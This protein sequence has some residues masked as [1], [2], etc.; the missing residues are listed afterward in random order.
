M[1]ESDVVK[2][3]SSKQLAPCKDHQIRDPITNR[4]RNKSGYKTK[5]DEQIVKPVK[6]S[7]L[8]SSKQLAPCKD[9]QIRDPVTNR[10]RNKSGYKTK[11]DEQITKP[12]KSSKRKSSKQLAPCKDHQIR[13]PITNRCRNKSGYKTKSD[14]QIAKPAKSSKRKSSKQLAPC[15][16]HQ[17]RDPV[18]NR[19]RNKSGYKTKTKSDEQIVKPAKSSKRKSSKQLAPC[20]DHQIRD[21]ITNRCRNKSEKKKKSVR[22]PEP[23]IEK[24]ERWKRV[25]KIAAN[26]VKRSKMQ[27]R[28][29]QIK[30]VEY[31]ENN[32]SLIVVHGTGCGKTLTAITCTQC[33]L[34]LH[35]ERRVVFVGPASLSSNFKKEMVNYGVENKEKYTFYSY[36]KFY[37]AHKSGKKISLKNTFLVIDEAH[38]IRNSEGGKSMVLA[39]AAFQADKR[40]L[41][42]AT[43]FVNSIEDFIPLINIVHGKRIVGTR[44]EF[45]Q[46]IVSEWLCKDLSEQNLETF[47][48][49]LEDYID[50]VDC[51]E[52][53][54][55]PERIDHYIDVP[56]SEDYY[57]RY[58][59]L[60]GGLKVFDL[61]FCNPNK[62]YNG[63]R[64]AVN[65]AGKEYYSKKI[66]AAL[67]V[68]NDGKCIIFTNWVE[69]GIK[70]IIEAL[71][72][73]KISYNV[74][75]GDIP[76]KN[77][78]QIVDDFNN[79]KFNV[80]ILTRAGGEGID[81]KGV[82]SV[83]VLDPTWNDAGLQQIIGR[84]I[85][86]K[87][88]YHLPKKERKV[89]VYFMMLS[90]P[91]SLEE[92]EAAASGDKLLYAIIE[93]KKIIFSMLTE[94]L[95][96]IS[97]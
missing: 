55:F 37:N 51:K 53:E 16:D 72:Q 35:P 33:Y 30:V 95:K 66:E 74:F 36:D 6:P 1:S 5:N 68:L 88:H 13:D 48:Y 94:I 12:A 27:L 82:K 41:L 21:P 46:N 57:E 62:F 63:Y 56:M 18:T 26:C 15:K 22:E 69:F 54:F 19:C 49:L 45:N 8:K 84:A 79:D 87:S 43:P 59:A 80:L 9:H 17:I 32:D 89:D 7:K 91:D 25:Q 96:E 92:E 40:L 38:N 2:R 90:K 3:K 47:R 81:L 34:D 52:P 71:K 58:L 61:V 42:T 31:M 86:Y 10:C 93:R 23:R 83:V 20:K 73:Y 64:R 14:E 39:K 78:Q 77:R 70:P 44:K 75:S 67:P 50:I 24:T 85:R 11:N 28:D 29:L 65:K 76:V 97:I 4:C 60:I